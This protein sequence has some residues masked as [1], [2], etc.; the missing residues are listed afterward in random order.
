[1]FVLTREIASEK[2]VG[3]LNDRKLNMIFHGRRVP[4]PVLI[5]SLARE[6]NSRLVGVDDE[7]GIVP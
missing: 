5:L 6:I 3:R 2:P 1:M 7:V 4:S